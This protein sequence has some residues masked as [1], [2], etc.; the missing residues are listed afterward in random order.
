MGDN[1][2]RQKGFAVV[3]TILILVI[4][5]LIGGTGYY[6]WHSNQ[7]ASKSYSA[8][9]KSVPSNS[10]TTNS[11]ELSQAAIEIAPTKFTTFSK[12]PNELQKVAIAEMIKQVPP[13]VKNGKLVDYQGKVIDPVVQYAPVGSAIIGIGCEGGAA[14]LFAKNLKNG[15]W[16][17]VQATQD[18]FT[19][20]A[21][22]KN[23]VPKS[24]LA[25]D[26]ARAECYDNSSNILDYDTASRKYFY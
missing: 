9:S 8:V 25:R 26:G 10:V 19:C 17:Y 18:A 24:L 16:K 12:L 14:G 21:V 3:E 1:S 7:E 23:P 13:C 5:T 20:D 4:A 15:E 6:V 2:F 22:F 11:S